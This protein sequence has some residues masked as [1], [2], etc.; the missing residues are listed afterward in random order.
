M[1][2]E[3][4]G[5]RSGLLTQFSVDFRV[6]NWKTDVTIPRIRDLRVT[7]SFKYQRDIIVGNRVV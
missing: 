4:M 3:S 7:C 2:A 5:S 6:E 1:S